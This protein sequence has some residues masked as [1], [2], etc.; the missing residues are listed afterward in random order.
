MFSDENSYW[1][2]LVLLDYNNYLF[3]LFTFVI[4]IYYW[5]ISRRQNTSS[6]RFCRRVA[7]LW[8]ASL[9]VRWLLSRVPAG[10]EGLGT[11]V[12]VGF[13]SL[14][15]IIFKRCKLGTVIMVPYWQKGSPYLLSTTEAL[16]FT[17]SICIIMREIMHVVI[18]CSVLTRAG[19]NLAAWQAANDL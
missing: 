13:G 18:P 9:Q 3:T 19:V 12:R 4:W 15:D 10:L 8:A 11:E 2:L 17:F 6:T 14:S 1:C 7:P 16:T 5:L